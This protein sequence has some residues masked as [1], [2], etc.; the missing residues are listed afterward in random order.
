MT[1]KPHLGLLLPAWILPGSGHFLMGER[2]KGFTI[3][4]VING[5]WIT[6]ALLSDFEAISKAF[7]PYLVWLGAGC[8]ATPLIGILFDP[9]AENLLQG[10]QS[11]NTYKDVG[12]YNDSGVQMVCFAG[13]LNVM[14][15]L[16]IAD[17]V[18]D[19]CGRKESESQ[20]NETDGLPAERK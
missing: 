17:R 12:Q 20:Q 5:L 15:L 4:A 10:I 11:V 14:V 16:D 7:H 8:G 18:I 1:K 6:G 13:L 3:F 2:L 9:V 19:P